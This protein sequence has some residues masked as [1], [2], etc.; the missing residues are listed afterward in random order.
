VV[1]QRFLLYS[2]NVV[3]EVSLASDLMRPLFHASIR[4]SYPSPQTGSVETEAGIPD[5]HASIFDSAAELFVS[6]QPEL[7]LTDGLPHFESS[8]SAA[9]APQPMRTAASLSSLNDSGQATAQTQQ[10]SRSLPQAASMPSLQ[11][12]RCGD[13]RL[14][15]PCT[16]TMVC[17]LPEFILLLY[18]TFITL[19]V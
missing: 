7:P 1:W 11:S 12:A 6:P 14:L 4:H 13:M 5:A 19:C 18:F 10:Q 15:S 3:V 2:L 17:F 9:A 8:A 16:V